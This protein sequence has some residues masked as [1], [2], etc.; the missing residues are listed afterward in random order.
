MFRTFFLGTWTCWWYLGCS[1]FNMFQSW[2]LWDERCRCWRDPLRPSDTEFVTR[3]P[4]KKP[5][6]FLARQG[7][8]EGHCGHEFSRGSQGA[9]TSKGAPFSTKKNIE[10]DWLH[11]E[12]PDFFFHETYEVEI[13]SYPQ[14]EGILGGSG[15]LGFNTFFFFVEKL[16]ILSVPM[17]EWWLISEPLIVLQRHVSKNSYM[18]TIIML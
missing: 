10:E 3:G 8:N 6:A 11:S 4:Q 9:N 7:R 12:S 17:T 15:I 14:N 16:G 18:N 5:I 2:K 13:E 1:I